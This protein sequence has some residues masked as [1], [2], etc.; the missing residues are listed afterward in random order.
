VL[1][2]I[3]ILILTAI[4]FF[5]LGYIAKELTLYWVRRLKKADEQLEIARK[6][7]HDKDKF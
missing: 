1:T 4:C 7:I 2:A 6:I 5:D 3:I